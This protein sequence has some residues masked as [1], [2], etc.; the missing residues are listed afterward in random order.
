MYCAQVICVM[1]VWSRYVTK[2]LSMA[3]DRLVVAEYGSPYSAAQCEH[4]LF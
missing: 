3:T 1:S 2:S 4:N